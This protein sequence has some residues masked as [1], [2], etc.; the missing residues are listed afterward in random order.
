MKCLRIRLLFLSGRFG[1][2]SLPRMPEKVCSTWNMLI[3]VYAK[4]P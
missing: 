1:K 2:A 4:K 3:P